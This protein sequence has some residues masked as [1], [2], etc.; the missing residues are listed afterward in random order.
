ML[1]PPS[2]EE[3]MRS[4]SENESRHQLPNI[5]H[6][7]REDISVDD[8]EGEEFTFSHNVHQTRPRRLIPIQRNLQIPH[9][10]LVNHDRS[11]S[12]HPGVPKWPWTETRRMAITGPQGVNTLPEVE[13]VSRLSSL[14]ISQELDPM[15]LGPR[16]V[17][18]KCSHCHHYIVT[19]IEATFGAFACLSSSVLCCFG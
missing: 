17:P 14:P 3:S 5:Q 13:L 1:A 11:L 19:K 4:P 10:S 7:H 15:R 9:G 2:Y 8:I 12:S 16:A 6:Q 18:T